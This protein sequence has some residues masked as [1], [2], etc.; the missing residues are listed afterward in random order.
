MGDQDDPTAEVLA[1]ENAGLRE[2]N[3]T[4]ARRAA[5]GR[6]SDYRFHD[7][8]DAFAAMHGMG[9]LQGVQIRDDG[10]VDEVALRKAIR[11]F[12]REHPYFVDSEP[13][14]RKPPP[15]F[16]SGANVGGGRRRYGPAVASEEALKRK[17][18][19]LRR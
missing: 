7:A 4:V 12:A 6:A 19:A 13:E 2:Q 14:V 15:P 10:T 16:P 11:T 8:S 17:Y 9:Y 5:F 18:P 3:L 1:A